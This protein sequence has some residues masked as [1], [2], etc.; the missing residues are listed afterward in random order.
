MRK[1]PLTPLT[2]SRRRLIQTLG[3]SAALSLIG[4]TELTAVGLPTT[5]R[6]L[7][8]ASALLAARI[9]DG[10]CR[11]AFALSPGRPLVW[12]FSNLALL[13]FAQAGRQDWREMIHDYL[14]LYL[15]RQSKDFTIEDVEQ[16]LDDSGRT[17]PDSHDA[18]A[19]TF[20]ELACTYASTY[21]D[22]KWLRQRLRTLK[23]MAYAN[24]AKP[25]QA[26]GLV[27]A[28]QDGTGA[29]FL[30][31][32]CENWSGLNALQPWLASARDSDA[33]YFERVRNAILAGINSLFDEQAG[34]WLAA[35]LKMAPGFYPDLVC[36][37][38]AEAWNV[39]VS[40]A[41]K[42]AGYARLNLLAPRWPE[43]IYDPFPWMILGMVA[44][45]RGDRKRAVEQRNACRRLYASDPVHVTCNEL[46][47]LYATDR[48]LS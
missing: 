8:P 36:Q 16:P 44:A 32:N 34:W 13:P 1:T 18:Y 4:R 39:P 29:G 33:A 21:A 25:Q 47:W 5:E 2:L 19:S 11:G 48:M 23:D 37:V 3:G 30:N 45:G 42:D 6:A 41:S 7:D 46:G 15:S 38:F 12:Y 22:H 17:A 43:G 26:S 9:A 31:D 10:P 27:T 14:E 35:D 40:Q 24:L 28:F 20:I